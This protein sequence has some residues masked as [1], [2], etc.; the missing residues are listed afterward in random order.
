MN[1]KEVIGLQDRIIF[2]AEPLADDLRKHLETCASC[3]E[4]CANALTAREVM[5]GVRRWEPVLTNPEVMT[6]NILRAIDEVPRRTAIIP[7]VVQRLLAAASVALFLLF[8]YEQYGVVTKVTALEKQIMETSPDYRYSD[9]R[10][11]ASDLALHKAGLS[12]SEVA[13]LISSV[14][15][16]TRLSFSDIN[17]IGLNGH[18]EHR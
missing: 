9:L 3:S 12:F 4:A 10:P 2:E 6:D 1:C 11:L 16:T 18:T 13:R 14:K 15:G 8:G 5:A 7:M 17:T